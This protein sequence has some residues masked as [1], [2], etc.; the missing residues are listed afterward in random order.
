MLIQ[1]KTDAFGFLR[2]GAEI[3]LL[4]ND[5]LNDIWIVWDEEPGQFVDKD[6]N[7]TIEVSP[8]RPASFTFVQQDGDVVIREGCA[9]S[10]AK[11]DKAGLYSLQ[12]I[13][14]GY[15]SIKDLELLNL[16]NSIAERELNYAMNSTLLAAL[17]LTSAVNAASGAVVKVGSFT[18]DAKS[19]LS[20]ASAAR[21]VNNI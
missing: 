20:T 17:G 8:S 15:D 2:S 12:G 10:I 9:L 7:I 19:E 18:E 6:G 5:T 1:A 16:F 13:S 3:T 14:T 4:V 11:A 21:T